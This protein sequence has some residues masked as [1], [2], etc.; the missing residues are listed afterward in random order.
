[1]T[2]M[3]IRIIAVTA[4][5]LV[6]ALPAVAL[7]GE[8]QYLF[9][10]KCGLCHSLEQSMGAEADAVGWAA[11]MARMKQKASGLISDEEAERILEYILKTKGVD[12]K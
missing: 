2:R 8:T 5:A 3:M 6:F 4:L 1:M 11:I 10:D 9:E 12:G 7:S